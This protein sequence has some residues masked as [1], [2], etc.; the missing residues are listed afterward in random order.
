[1]EAVRMASKRDYY[2]V[3]GVAKDAPPDEIKRAYR[4]AA[5]KFHPDRNRTD[6][7]AET[8][9]KEAAEAY[10]VLSDAQ[11]RQRYDRFGHQG[12]SSSGMHDFSHMGVE[13]IFSM[14]NDIF[15]GAFGGRGGGGAGRRR[16]ADLQAEI[17]ITLNEAATGVE[18]ELAF[19]RLDTCEFCE[20][21]GAAPGSTR[22]SCP[23]CG[24]YGQVE[25]AGGFGGL[26][27]RVV[28]VCPD[29]RGQ[30]K[31]VTHPCG[32]CR[33]RGSY[34]K[35][36]VVNVKI[37]AGIHD[38]QAIRVRGEGEPGD[39]GSVPGDLHCYVR[40]QPHDF[41]ERHENDLVCH[42]PIA[43]TQAALGASLEVPTLSGRAELTVP[44]GTQH[45]QVFRLRG[46]GM[47]DLRSGRAGDELV[48]VLVE[49]P[50]KLS[51]RQEELLREF[52]ATEDR[53]VLPESKR[54][55]ERLKAYFGA[56]GGAE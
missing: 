43:F 12:V 31:L 34:P 40:V 26:F 45:G 42:M 36:R 27:G 9:F 16:G 22:Q 46:L 18:K 1:M 47:P 19:K 55:F 44:P 53:A 23:T 37:P 30:G 21:T 29:C 52:A 11:K 15:G 25:Q 39:A 17:A 35:K 38:G 54:F 20:G 48:Q 13:D 32:K 7:D 56:D 10:E 3:L 24:G 49:I 51:P 4:K 28:T 33:G 2:E 6:P 14:F 50:K 8:K 5:L 41:L